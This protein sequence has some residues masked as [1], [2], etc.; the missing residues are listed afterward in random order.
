MEENDIAA[1]PRPVHHRIPNFV[2]SELTAKQ[3]CEPKGV[4]DKLW[5]WDGL[6]FAPQVFFL[7]QVHCQYFHSSSIKLEA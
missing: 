5:V 6:E 4:G 1:N 7:L 3:V 2:Q